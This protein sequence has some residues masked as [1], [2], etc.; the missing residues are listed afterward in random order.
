MTVALIAKAD[1]DAKLASLTERVY[2][3]L[4][5]EILTCELEP[6]RDLSE[7]ELAARFE[8]SKTPVR[9]ALA[10][11]RT[12][13]FIRS[14]PRRGYQVV[15]V[16]FGDIDE[17]FELRTILESAAAE[18]AC[19]RLT[20]VELD[21]L[22]TLADVI[23]DRAEQPTL[24]RF[25]DANR[26]FHLAI[27]KA[28]G[29]ERLNQQIARTIGELERFFYLGARLRDVSRETRDD[30]HRIVD[31]LRTREPTAAR[32]IMLDHNEATRQGLIQKIASAKGMR[33]V[34]L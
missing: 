8:V 10:T 15:P 1:K 24:K 2:A 28:S 3:A 14:F 26:D 19:Q 7:A 4:R 21:Q 13:G 34:E 30:H 25:I 18:L 31:V 22:A 33:Q 9:E 6:G 12:E 23:Y 20:D 5:K 16:T 17:L 32:R 27:G 11:L 29:N